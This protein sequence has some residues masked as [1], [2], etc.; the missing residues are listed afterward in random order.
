LDKAVN[1][2]GMDLLSLRG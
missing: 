1:V 2:V